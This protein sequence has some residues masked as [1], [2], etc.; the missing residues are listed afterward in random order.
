LQNIVGQALIV[1]SP[2][3]VPELT[4]AAARDGVHLIE[5]SQL[6]GEFVVDVAGEP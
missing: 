2:A 6:G 3:G 4:I 5:G 1:I